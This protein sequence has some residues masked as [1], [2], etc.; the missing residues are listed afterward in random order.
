MGVSADI[1]DNMSVADFVDKCIWIFLLYYVVI[2]G[3]TDNEEI[4]PE[5]IQKMHEIVDDVLGDFVESGFDYN[6]GFIGIGVSHELFGCGF[7][8]EG[9]FEIVLAYLRGYFITV[10]FDF[11][12]FIIKIKLFV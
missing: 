11:Y 7:V 12:V 9:E 8:F 2:S 10:A 5:R 4:P 1:E 6:C 3:I